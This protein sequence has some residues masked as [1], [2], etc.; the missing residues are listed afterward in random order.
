MT[1]EMACAIG[2]A[3]FMVAGLSALCAIFCT[4]MFVRILRSRG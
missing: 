3:S 2:A 1:N 4:V